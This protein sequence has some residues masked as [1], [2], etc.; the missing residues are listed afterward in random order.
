MKAT[1]IITKS[2]DIKVLRTCGLLTE[3][4]LTGEELYD[5]KSD[6][7]YTFRLRVTNLLKIVGCDCP[8]K[9]DSLSLNQMCALLMPYALRYNLRSITDEVHCPD[10]GKTYE[11][12][13]Y[14]R[15]NW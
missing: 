8:L 1:E 11:C 13:S 15:R 5:S 4:D 2:R 6:L 14:Y 7:I 12:P 9:L 10:T 3:N